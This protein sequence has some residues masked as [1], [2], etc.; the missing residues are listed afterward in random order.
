MLEPPLEKA[1]RRIGWRVGLGVVRLW[2]EAGTLLLIVLMLLLLAP[3]VKVAAFSVLSTTSRAGWSRRR[4]MEVGRK[5]S[6]SSLRRSRIREV[7][8]SF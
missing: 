8:K 2:G 4:C 3:A 5:M 7:G 6:R 1:V